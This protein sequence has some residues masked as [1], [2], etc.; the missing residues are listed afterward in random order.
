MARGGR[1]SE[2]KKPEAKEPPVQERQEPSLIRT[3]DYKAQYG[4]VQVAV[5]KRDTDE[6]TT[7]SVSLT[8]SYLDKQQVWQRTSQLDED[9]LMPAGLALTE[10]YK[11]IQGERQRSRAATFNEL[12]A[13]PRAANS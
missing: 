4:R 3:P 13:P 8:R 11:W 9:D 7:F 6:R 12:H 10:A 5:W 2:E 1:M